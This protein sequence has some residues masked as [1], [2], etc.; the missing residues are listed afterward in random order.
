MGTRSCVVLIDQDRILMVRQFYRGEEIW[1]FPGG[2]IE[3][4]ETPKEAA[5]R[6]VKEET[7]YDIEII[8]FDRINGMYYCF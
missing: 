3:E 7:N 6:E 8:K 4:Y 5:I 2:N 1:T